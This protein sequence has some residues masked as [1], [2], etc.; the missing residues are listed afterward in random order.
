MKDFFSEH[1]IKKIKS[2]A[3]RRKKFKIIAVT[4]ILSV[5]FWQICVTAANKN[6]N[7]E[8]AFILLAVILIGI[9]VFV[10][11]KKI[12]EL[13]VEYE[14]AYTENYFD[15]DI[16]KNRAKRKNVLSIDVAEIEIM[17]HIDD[18]EHLALYDN[19]P[20]EDFS[21][22]EILG[23]TYVFVAVY[24]GKRK[25]IIIEPSEAMLKA[26]Y[27]DLTPRRMFLKK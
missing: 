5:L 8:S 20:T 2:E 23:N 1:L 4:I 13:N 24:K 17:A 14:Y 9:V 19:L 25:K 3:D 26:F 21:S 10:A 22:G 6:V 12:Q 11:Y 16:I 15:V 18:V 7:L 27:G